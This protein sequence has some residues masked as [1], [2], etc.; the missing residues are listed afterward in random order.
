M[1]SLSVRKILIEGTQKTLYQN[2]GQD[3]LY[4]IR[5]SGSK[6]K[7]SVCPL[8]HADALCLEPLELYSERSLSMPCLSDT[9]FFAV[10]SSRSFSPAI[11]KALC[12]LNFYEKKSTSRCREFPTRKICLLLI[13]TL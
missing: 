13:G 5:S 8:E 11:R 12:Q 4:L 1:H 6:H 3:P 2:T 9:V 7:A 10:T